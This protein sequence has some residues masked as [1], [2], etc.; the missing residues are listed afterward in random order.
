MLS[1][2]LIDLQLQ[3]QSGTVQ[4]TLGGKTSSACLAREDES[5]TVLTLGVPYGT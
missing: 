4:V 2:I 1:S 5:S 3:L